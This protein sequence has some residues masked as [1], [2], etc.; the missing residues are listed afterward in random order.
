MAGAKRLHLGCGQVYKPGY[1]N[2]DRYDQSVADEVADLMDLPHEDGSFDVAE[3]FHVIEH[4]DLVHSRYFL[5]E[6][7]RVLRPGGQLVLETPDLGES[8]RVLSRSDTADSVPITQWIYGQDSP[9]LQHRTGFTFS[10]L[11]GALEEAGFADIVREEPRTH[12]YEPGIRVVCTK[13]AK[14]RG[15]LLRAMVRKSVRRHLA[16]ADSYVLFPLEDTLKQVFETLEGRGRGGGEGIVSALATATVPDPRV[17]LAVLDALDRPGLV[18]QPTATR[19]RKVLS[20]LVDIDLKGRLFSVW[21][22]SRKGGDPDADFKKFFSEQAR[23]IAGLLGPDGDDRSLSYVMD[24]NPTQVPLLDRRLILMEAR[25]AYFVGVKRFSSR[26]LDD[27]E[28][29]FR[30]AVAINPWNHHS[31]W[32]LAR[33]SALKGAPPEVVIGF[34]EEALSRVPKG[35]PS[36]SIGLELDGFKR[37]GREGLPADPVPAYDQQ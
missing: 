13:P 29:Q 12:T 24:V 22:R 18:E 17:G 35:P 4:F 36:R 5:A 1:V 23:L 11:E 21:C 31:F 20:H 16:D 34:Y 7:Y 30:L 2:V 26:S 10:T 33:L 3:A 8:L 32:N 14:D 25:K 19:M 15:H 37:D 28:A 6:A 9:G 27:A